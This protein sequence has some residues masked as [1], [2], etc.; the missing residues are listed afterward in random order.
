[1]SRLDRLRR[2]YNEAHAMTDAETFEAHRSTLLA[3]AYRMLGDMARA[4]DVVQE[5]WMRWQRRQV[6]ALAPKAFLVTTVTRLCL[7]ELGSARARREESRGDRLPEPVDLDDVG[8]G[9]L[10]MLDQVSMAFLVVL[11]RLTPLERAVFLL[12]DVFD[13]SHAE[14]GALL[15]RSDAACR[16]LLKRAREHVATERRVFE[17]PREEQRRLLMAFVSAIMG[18]DQKP[19]LD[20]LAEDAVLVPDAGPQGGGYGKIRKVG[21]PV[22]GRTKIAALVRAIAR[23]Q[24]A[25]GIVIRERLLNGEP[26]V[27]AFQNGQAVLAILV[28]VSDGR[29]RHIFLHADTDRLRHVGAPN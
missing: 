27:V 18:G 5:A 24:A 29:I 19:L 12:H 9:R 6:E 11:Q 14:I 7:D 3:L 21:R 16:Q 4:E 22:V 20:V 17:T 15:T 23:Q 8:M 1:M 2:L 26:A 10:E 25:P 13:M 28:S